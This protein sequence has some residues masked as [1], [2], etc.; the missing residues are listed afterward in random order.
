M[1]KKNLEGNLLNR[2]PAPVTN[3]LKRAGREAARSDSNLYLVGGIVRD[4][5]LGRPGKDIDLMIEGNAIAL[6]KR[7]ASKNNT[8]LTV[9]K[10]F[11]TATFHFQ[12]YRIDLATCRSETYRRPGALPDVKPGDIREDLSR[13]DFTINAMAIDLSPTRYGQLIDLYGGGA[14][15]SNGLIRVLHDKSFEDDATRIMRAIRYEQRL[16]FK[17]E[18]RTEKLLKRNLPLLDTISSERLRKEVLLWLSEESPQRILQRADRLGILAKIHPSL[19]WDNNLAIAFKRAS[20]LPDKVN[21]ESLYF[22]L[23]AYHLT[24]KELHELLQRLNLTGTRLD[25][26]THCTIEIKN[27]RD[28]LLKEELKNSELYFLLK[29]FP[30]I[31][32]QANYIYPNPRSMRSRLGLYLNKLVKVQTLTRGTRLISLGIREGPIIGKI[33]RDLLVARLDGKVKTRN[34]EEQL[35]IKLA[36]NETSL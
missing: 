35:A 34:E 31:S 29:G 11:G 5:L 10:K 25:L 17:L 2:L 19:H 6:A 33:L 24:E 22:C 14:D 15:L 12:D 18:R 16:G 7:L 13:R 23:L 30:L 4:L 32:I 9:H 20:L 26:L 27:R 1:V 3:L 8:K 36:A 21:K 28:Q